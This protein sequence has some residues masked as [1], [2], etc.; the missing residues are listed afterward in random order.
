MAN[1]SKILYLILSYEI[2]ILSK[3]HSHIIIS[4]YNASIPTLYMINKIK[5]V[6][7]FCV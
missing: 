4:C 1:I 3:A 5:P 2:V 7:K 6:N